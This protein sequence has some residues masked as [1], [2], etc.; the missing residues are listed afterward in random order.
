MHGVLCA[1]CAF[2]VKNISRIIAAIDI[3]T[4]PVSFHDFPKEIRTLDDI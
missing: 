1:L 4:L 2:A 3:Y